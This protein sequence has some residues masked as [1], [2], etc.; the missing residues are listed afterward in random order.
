MQRRYNLAHFILAGVIV[1]GLT[2]LMVC[3]DA[4]AR[5]AFGSDRDGNPEIY[6]MDA[7]GRNQQRLTENLNND[8][9]PSWS[10]DDKRIAFVSNR[11]G[12]FNY[13]IYVIDADGGNEQRLTN[14]PDEDKFPS[15]SPDGKR[16]VFSARR[17]GHFENK[18]AITEEIYVMDADGRNQQRLTEN[19]FS[20]W[21]PSWS[22]DGKRIT[23]ASDRKGDLQNFEIYV[24]DANGRNQQRLTNN[25]HQDW[26]PSWSPDG[27]RI[28]FSSQR[29]GNYEIYVM[30]ADGENQRNLTNNSHSD[31]SPAWFNSPFSVSPAGK[32]FTMWG[33]LKQI[34]R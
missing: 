6:V 34:D 22:P 25:R 24:M 16:I 7:D 33:W 20:D 17:A 23:F 1:L 30:D 31:G 2:L 26:K 28:A 18:F 8:W 3:V 10:P 21:Y 29:D 27:K 9:S 32:K 5:I 11:D 14:N 15:W 12:H 4:Q 13:E 19:L